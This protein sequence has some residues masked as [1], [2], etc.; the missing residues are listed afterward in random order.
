LN[1]HPSPQPTHDKAPREDSQPWL[2]AVVI[3]NAREYAIF[4]TDLE[5]RVTSWNTGAQRV[6][7]FGEQE[8]MGQLAD[9][10]FTPEDRAAGAPQREAK[11]ALLEG[12]AADERFHQRKDGSLF[13][14]SGALMLMRDPAGHAVGFVKI[15]RDQSAAREAQQA[16]ERSQLELLSALEVARAAR[17]ELQQADAAKD[18][19]LAVLSHE[20]RNPLASIDSA[21]TLLT[22][23]E[24]TAEDRAAAAQVVARQA[25]AMTILLDDLLDIS[26]LTLGR[27]R[28]QREPVRLS[29]VV[30]QALESVRPMLESAGHR[31]SIDLPPRP[32]TLDADPVRLAQVFSNLL[33]NSIKYTPSGGTISLRA[34]TEAAEVVVTVS[35]NGIGMEPA[36]IDDMFEMFTQGRADGGRSAGGLG[37]GLALARSIVQLHGGRISARSGGSGSG[38]EFTVQLPTER[39]KAAP[40]PVSS[41]STQQ[42]ASS[43]RGW[44]LV[45]DDN[46]DVGWGMARLLEVAGYKTVVVRSG[47]DA[48][49]EATREMPDIAILDIGMPD[50]SGHEVA[51]QLRAMEDGESLVLIAVTG[52][53]QA[54]EEHASLAAGFD[55]HMTK[56]VNLRK[57]SAQVDELMER[58]RRQKPDCQD[59]ILC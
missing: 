42:L 31:L 21:A 17:D 59:G 13:W 49:A 44:I 8:A 34:R 6:L 56:P 4:S 37:I 35:D 36:Q 47:R 9:F 16:L 12:R 38:S 46:A 3:E 7:G 5:R 29:K 19:F 53:G 20:L 15:L 40:R 26:R 11:T 22:S 58:K 51:R 57:L 33:T 52:W 25:A 23:A 41:T 18:R 10:I 30:D 48:L 45:A 39:G 1:P 24:T 50:L 27:L 28:L 55:A 54:A 2:A 32:V 14:A 43:K